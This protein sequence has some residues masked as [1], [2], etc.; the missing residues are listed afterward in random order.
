MT[1]FFST[2]MSLETVLKLKND[3]FLHYKTFFTHIG[4]EECFLGCSDQMGFGTV[5]LV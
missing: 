2:R 3:L 5:K 1:L 4:L